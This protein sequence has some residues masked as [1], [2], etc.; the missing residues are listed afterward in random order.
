M[1]RTVAGYR[2]KNVNSLGNGKKIKLSGKVLFLIWPLFPREQNF[3]T[4]KRVLDCICASHTDP[5]TIRHCYKLTS[6]AILQIFPAR[7][8]PHQGWYLWAPEWR[9]DCLRPT[10]LH[11]HE[12]QQLLSGGWCRGRSTSQPLTVLR[13][14]HPGSHHSCEHRFARWL[15]CHANRMGCH[16]SKRTN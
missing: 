15:A 6:K 9:R 2:I 10:G 4:R 14:H 12:L 1:L 13:R 8:P 16:F 7:I 11:S 5:S 3:F